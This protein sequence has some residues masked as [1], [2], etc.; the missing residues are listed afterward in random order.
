M[1]L[2]TCI[3][4]TEYLSIFLWVFWFVSPTLLNH[5]LLLVIIFIHLMKFL[6]NLL[7][8]TQTK[9]INHV[10][11]DWPNYLSVCDSI[12]TSPQ[13]SGVSWHLR[14]VRWVNIWFK[15]RFLPFIAINFI[16]WYKTTLVI[17]GRKKTGFR[18]E[19]QRI[20][21]D[22]FAADAVGSF[23]ELLLISRRK[24]IVQCYFFLLYM[25]YVLQKWREVFW[26]DDPKI[27]IFVRCSPKYTHEPF[28]NALSINQSINQFICPF[29]TY[30]IEI[31]GSRLEPERCFS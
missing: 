21:L 27:L 17:A 15:H 2:Y 16:T 14:I 1:L 31:T 23:M 12:W 9:C 11:H 13:H 18:N 26:S 25:R 29:F 24:H 4:F 7:W 19:R 28:A 22:K 10:I 30:N 8:G 3:K 6:C 20:K 5:W